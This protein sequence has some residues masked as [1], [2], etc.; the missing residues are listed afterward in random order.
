[1]TIRRIAGAIL[2]T[3]VAA[4]VVLAAPAIAS[5]AFTVSGTR[6]FHPPPYPEQLLPDYFA[7][8]VITRIDYP[9]SILGMDASVAVATAGLVDAVQN[10]DGQLVAAGFS[11]GAIAVGYAKQALMALPA[12]LRPA[13]DRLGFVTVGDPTGAQGILRMLPFKVPLLDLTPFSPPETPYDTVVVNGEYDGWADFPD[14]PWNLVSLVNALL[15][16]AYVHG[17]YETVPGGLDLSTVPPA[18][19]TTSTN[20]LGGTTTVYLI[21]TER[22]P[23]V[24][25][26]RDIGVPEPVVAALETPLKAMVDAGYVRN[27][28][29]VPTA[30]TVT[31]TAR[32]GAGRSAAAMAAYSGNP[33]ASAASPGRDQPRKAAR[34]GHRRAAA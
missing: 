4:A 30:A 7:G 10:G 22:L 8:D 26:L 18:N 12:D 15:G 3:A 6:T 11:Q 20:S 14:R 9:A 25:P 34:Q 16:T 29:P 17:G 32:G 19:I 2:S 5:T 23:L 24:Q 28:P 33:R 31:G 21:P 1:M 27:D 13:A